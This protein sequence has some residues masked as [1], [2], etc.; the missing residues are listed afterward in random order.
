ALALLR[1]GKAEQKLRE[2]IEAQGG[3][4]NIKVSDI[5]VGR[6]KAAIRSNVSGTVMWIS[7]E[8]L[9]KICQAAGTPN[10]KGAGVLLKKKI[11]DTVKKG[12]VL[13]EI[14]AE[15]DYKLEAAIKLTKEAQSFGIA[16][17]IE[18]MMFIG[19]V[20]ETNHYKKWVNVER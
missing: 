16:Q 1:S 11:K 10:D 13:F 8:H 12:E 19:K 18:E 20:T 9:V 3:N 4:K 17:R 15:K 6:Y 7:N 5:P 14:Y 2:I